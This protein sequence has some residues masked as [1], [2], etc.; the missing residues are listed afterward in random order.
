MSQKTRELWLQIHKWSGLATFIILFVVALTG[1]VLTFRHSLDAALNPQLFA[2]RQPGPA[3]PLPDLM[4]RAEAQRPQLRVVLALAQIQPGRTAVFEVAP[5]APG[6]VLDYTQVFVEPATGQILGKRSGQAGWGRADILQGVYDL[7]VRLMAGGAGRVILGVVSGVWLVSSLVGAY[8]TLPRS[9]PFWQRWRPQWTVAWRAKVPRLMLDLHRASGLW[10]FIGVMALSTTGL[11]LNFYTELS[12][13]LA[14]A[15]SPSR[16]VEPRGYRS[17]AAPLA[18]S[19]AQAIDL[20]QAGARAD[21]RHLRLAVASLDQDENVY[22]I[23]FSASGARDYWWLGPVYYYID[24]DTGAITAKDDPYRDSLGRVALRSLYPIHSG[25]MFG[26][27]ARLMIFVS[28]LATAV[29][30]VTGAYVW[31]R[32]RK[33]RAAQIRSQAAQTAP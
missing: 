5:R 3:L 13:P 25:R 10:L 23:G 11:L 19:Y 16:F 2:A 9:G 12:E 24:A 18:V 22:R 14:H 17:G 8:L 21:G 29:M 4:A 32:K 15:L 31:L 7:H 6:A 33:A 1:C 26:W 28:G 27:T 30:A 20:A